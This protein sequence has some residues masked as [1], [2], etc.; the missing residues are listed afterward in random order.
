MKSEKRDF[1]IEFVSGLHIES[2]HSKCEKYVTDTTQSDKSSHM[3]VCVFMLGVQIH[4]HVLS[5]SFSA[6]RLVSAVLSRG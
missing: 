2:H 1:S 6:R 3:F 5:F 4:G